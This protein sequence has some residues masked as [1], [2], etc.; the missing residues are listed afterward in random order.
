MAKTAV[1]KTANGGFES[2]FPLLPQICV[3]PQ[4][5]GFSVQKGVRRDESGDVSGP[6]WQGA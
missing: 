5:W 4:V 2:L 6:C 1:S 3:I